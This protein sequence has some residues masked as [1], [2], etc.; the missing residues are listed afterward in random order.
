MAENRRKPLIRF[1]G[2]TDDWEQRKFVSFFC[3]LSNNTLSRAELSDSGTI[4]NIHYGDILVKFGEI[5]DSKH[6]NLPFV[7]DERKLG[8]N[9]S[10]ENGDIVI[11]DTAEDIT[12]GKCVEVMV[13]TGVKV[14]SGLHTI[15]CRPYQQYARGY[16]AY[17]MNSPS[18]HNQLVPLMQGTKVTSISKSA[19]Q[20]TELSFPYAIKEQACLGRLF[21]ALDHLITLHQRKRIIE[22]EAYY[23][24]FY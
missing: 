12:A 16:L 11:A 18:Y 22:K 2:F 21:I 9:S 24:K 7:V 19:L 15:P 13:E 10:L 4:K 17:Y 20:E 6:D 3:M 5:I 1:K 14:V 23:V 8:K